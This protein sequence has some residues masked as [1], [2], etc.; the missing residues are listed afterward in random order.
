MSSKTGSGINILYLLTG[1]TSILPV[2]NSFMKNLFTTKSNEFNQLFLIG[3]ASRLYSRIGIHCWLASD[4]NPPLLKQLFLLYQKL[5]LLH[6]KRSFGWTS[7]TSK[8]LDSRICT[9]RYL[10]SDSHGKNATEREHRRWHLTLNRWPVH[11]QDEF[12][13]FYLT[14]TVV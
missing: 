1:P 10:I 14:F 6:G 7:E 11:I 3:Q 12:F 9:P 5:H 2:W 8:F 13:T 4:V